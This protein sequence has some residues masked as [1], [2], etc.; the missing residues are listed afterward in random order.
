MK[1]DAVIIKD[2]SSGLFAG[3]VKQYPNVC[4]QADTID[5]VLQNLN[6][7]LK[8]WLAYSAEN[9]IVENTEEFAF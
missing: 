4:S 9:S 8:H 1:V 7:Y 6:S 2:K 3:F 5:N